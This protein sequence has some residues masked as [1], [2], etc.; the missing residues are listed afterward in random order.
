MYVCMYVCIYVRMCVYMYV[1]T[2]GSGEGHRLHG[3]YS[4]TI[5]YMSNTLNTR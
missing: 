3:R 1:C 2:G 5:H 4:V